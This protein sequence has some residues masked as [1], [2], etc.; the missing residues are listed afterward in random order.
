MNV[1]LVLPWTLVVTRV[2]RYGREN[3]NMTQGR[4]RQSFEQVGQE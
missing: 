2:A 1:R 3:E 4:L